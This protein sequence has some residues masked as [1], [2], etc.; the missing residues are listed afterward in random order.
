MAGTQNIGEA[1]DNPVGINIT[2][3]V[4]IIFCL[5]LFFMCSLHFKQL[6]GKIDSWLPTKKGNQVGPIDHPP[7]LEEVRV[8]MRWDSGSSRTIR[9]IGNRPPV[10]SDR[11]LMATIGELR[12]GY[13]QVGKL[14]VPILLDATQDVPWQEVIHVLDLCNQ[15]KYTKIEF[16]EPMQYRPR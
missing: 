5:C 4:D 9:S 14:E 1:A 8:F 3:M 2:A 13:E 6:E 10:S 11:D 12:K 16:V 15:E 7:I